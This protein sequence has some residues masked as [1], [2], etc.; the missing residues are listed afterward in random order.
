[1]APPANWTPVDVAGKY[2][3]PDGTL[4][5]GTVTFTSTPILRDPDLDLVIYPKPVQV[6][7]VAGAFAT[8]LMATDDPDIDPSF[9]YTCTEVIGGTTT[10]FPMIVPR[11]IA[12][13]GTVLQMADMDRNLTIP[14][15]PEVF[16]RTINGMWGDVYTADFDLPTP[17]DTVV[18]ETTF[19]NSSNPGTSPLLSRGDHTHGT[20]AAPAIPTASVT[21]PTAIVIAGATAIGAGTTWA[22]SDHAHAGP[23]FGSVT[24]QTSFG[25][26]S[27]NGAA[28]TP[29]RSDHTH[30]T[31]AA[32]TIPSASGTVVAETTYGLASGAG[33]AAT[34]SRGDHTHG[35]QATPTAATVGAIPNTNGITYFGAGLLSARPAAGTA[36]RTY[37]ATDL[38]TEFY[39]NGTYWIQHDQAPAIPNSWTAI[40]HSYLQFNASS[41]N[42]RS[43]LDSILR[44][45]W[46]V[47]PTNWVNLAIAGSRLTV[48]GAAQGGWSTMF[49]SVTK[50]PSKTSP[51]TSSDGGLLLCTGINDLGTLGGATAQMQTA[52][53]HG[54]RT[55]ISRWRASTIF[56]TTAAN[57]AFGGVWTTETTQQDIASGGEWR[58]TTANAATVTITLPADYNG[59]PV[60]PC[61]IGRPGANGATITFTGTALAGK[62]ELNSTINLNDV[63]PAAS[64]SNVPVIKRIT[65][66]TSA[67]A[68]Q[69]IICTTSSNIGLIYYDC[70]WLE[71]KEAPPV[72]ICNVARPTA[73]AISATWPGWTP[74]TASH[75][76]DVAAFNTVIT[77]VKNE[78]DTMVQVADID[79]V[80][81][82][83]ASN[84]T[85][86]LHPNEI[87]AAKCV[88]EIDNARRKLAP[89][90]TSRSA[91][92]NMNMAARYAGGTRVRRLKGYYHTAEFD[93]VGT[94]YAPVA[95]DMFA[96]PFEVT[97][98]D[99][100]FDRFA[101]EKVA[102]GSA[103]GT[104]RW[105]IYS[106]YMGKGYPDIQ[107]QELTFG[108]ALTVTN[109]SGVQ[110][111]PVSQFTWYPDI[112]LYWLV[113][114]I[115]TAGTGITYATIT[116]PNPHMPKATTAGAITTAPLAIGW[117]LTGQATGAFTS[118]PF[119]T[120]PAG[121]VPI[122]A[123]PYIG[124][125]K[126]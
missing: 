14:P 77:N 36:N 23:G 22:K 1:M 28:A 99:E 118:T 83:T 96:M 86:G 25:A 18:N 64:F 88:D 49:R 5:S 117:K 41:Y 89:T 20:P 113:M 81:A 24:A 44:G 104:I 121:A 39:D 73:A 65:S 34:F 53:G 70:W 15:E 103:T 79:T 50:L 85:D 54:M 26:S 19:G 13:L 59:E 17:A 30:G 9:Y 108:G 84:F 72:V 112:G 46:D 42:Q 38:N 57:T 123:A 10:S 82:K 97:E 78:F 87:G 106:D 63:M 7:L 74:A 4:A 93:L 75:D 107:L 29:A 45:R 37:Y 40:G 122:L 111:N 100:K 101:L 114:K 35:T 11:Q 126:S 61:F 32:P 12:D 115:E 68:G 90:G 27:G 98:M 33:A 105:G 3:Y 110:L 55:A 76:L 58:Y 91:A 31:P 94:A 80:L 120:F 60:V 67:N 6:T 124:C 92:L 95:G 125:L 2:I 119:T 16:V 116:G 102:A 47:E 48:Q 21:N 62:P 109:A 8:T 43:R 66:L 71:A 51:Y 69:T 56:E 52:F